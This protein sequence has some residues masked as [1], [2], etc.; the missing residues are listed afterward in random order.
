MKLQLYSA[1]KSTGS[2]VGFASCVCWASNDLVLTTADD[3]RLL[4]WSAANYHEPVKALHLPL[5]KN[6]YPTSMHLL[7]ITGGSGGISNFETS[8]SASSSAS[9]TSSSSFKID[10][11][12][13]IA[14]GS[15]IGHLHLL[16]LSWNGASSRGDRGSIEAHSGA[17][18][19][20]R[21][22][23]DASTLAT[24]GE[25]G[26]IKIWSRAGML[27][28]TINTSS[29][30]TA[31]TVTSSVYALSWSP[32]SNSLVYGVGGTSGRLVVK[33][34]SPQSRST[35]WTAHE[36]L[37]VC[38]AWSQLNGHILSAAEDGHV[39]MWDG[40]GRLLYSSPAA[41][42]SA[43]LATVA[44]SPDGE[45]FSVGGFSSLKLHDAASG[46]CLSLEKLLGGEGVVYSVGW[47]P[48]SNQLAAVC[49]GG[50]VLFA[51]VIERTLEGGGGGG[52]NG[53][54]WTVTT[55]S[56]R[57]IRVAN[58]TVADVSEVLEFSEAV[59]RLS[60]AYGHLVVV[61]G[62][63]C[64]VY[65]AVQPEPGANAGN[66]T[67]TASS[68]AVSAAAGWSTPTHFDVKNMEVLLVRQAAKH[69]LLVTAAA[70][71]LY[72]YDG[73]FLRSIKLSNLRLEAIRPSLIR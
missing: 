69:F 44:W 57:T 6:A 32:D 33:S 49:S 7:P 37:V 34:L 53:S 68:A 16:P 65:Q 58:A 15:S 19:V 62:S 64:F 60:F 42:N 25:D 27:R 29:A 39:R 31:Q 73:R 4:F 66:N 1:S 56:R 21:W 9:S 38:L 13:V 50:Q 71:S 20:L 35:E 23:N 72:S 14:I 43:P 67:S 52:G 2:H 12:S 59:T 54:A 51:Y 5:P 3:R 61:A 10:G 46:C 36:G 11:N 18:I 26:L 48:D 28:S 24:G 63:Q 40:S 30:G 45:L 8:S 70:G 22:S 17:I 41:T 47:S 55:T